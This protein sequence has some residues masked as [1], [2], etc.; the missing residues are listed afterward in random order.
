MWKQ[1]EIDHPPADVSMVSFLLFACF[2]N[3]EFITFS[4]KVHVHFLCGF[5]FSYGHEYCTTECMMQGATC[6]FIA[7]LFQQTTNC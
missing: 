1:R 2:Q 7:H 5:L 3:I 6:I 4:S